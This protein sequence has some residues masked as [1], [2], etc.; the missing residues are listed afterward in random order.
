MWNYQIGGYQVMDK[1]LK[2][3]KVCIIKRRNRA[4]H[5]GCCCSK[6]DDCGAERDLCGVCTFLTML[7]KYPDITIEKEPD[8]FLNQASNF[9][10]H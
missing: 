1:Y 9:F 5:E 10:P 4:L 7:N 8:D 3:P 6:K 2:D